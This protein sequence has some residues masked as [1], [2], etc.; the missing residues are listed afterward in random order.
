MKLFRHKSSGHRTKSCKKVLTE[1]S[2]QDTRCEINFSENIGQTVTV[3]VNSGGMAGNGFTGVLMSHSET[4]IRLLI[5]PS[6]PPACSIRSSCNSE[7][8][9]FCISCPFNTSG[10]I[11]SIAEISKQCIVAFVHNNLNGSR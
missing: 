9:M 8:I 10:S 4:S 1:I 6:V 5:I 2:L 7:N 3:F 11:G